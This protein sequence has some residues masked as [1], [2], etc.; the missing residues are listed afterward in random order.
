VVCNLARSKH[1]GLNGVGDGVDLLVF[2][3]TNSLKARMAELNLSVASTK[4]SVMSSRMPCKIHP[5]H[6]LQEGL[7]ADV[8]VLEDEIALA[9]RGSLVLSKH[10]QLANS[11]RVINLGIIKLCLE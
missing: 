8:Q 4:S 6:F 3:A 1:H 5:F 10:L 2:D 7:L 9:E 11:G